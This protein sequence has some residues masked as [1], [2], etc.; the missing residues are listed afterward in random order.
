MDDIQVRAVYLGH[1]GTYF[2]FRLMLQ[3]KPI[4]GYYPA[5]LVDRWGPHPINSAAVAHGDERVPS[6][7]L[8]GE[9]VVAFGEP[10]C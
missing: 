8:V 2:V 3:G 9:R 1:R 7:V 6:P 10:V 5:W 4:I